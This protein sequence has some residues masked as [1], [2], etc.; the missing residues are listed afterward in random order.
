MEL[1]PKDIAWNKIFEQYDIL[2]H[3]FEASPFILSSEEI[4]R[5]VKNLIRLHKRNLVYFA[6]KIQGKIDLTFL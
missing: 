2:S 4:K 6:T 3:D 5:H 1:S